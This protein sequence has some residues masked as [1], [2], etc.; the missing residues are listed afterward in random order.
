MPALQA[1]RFYWW[2]EF[3]GLQSKLSQGGLSALFFSAWSGAFRR[4][5][6]SAERGLRRTALLR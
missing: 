1:G 2:G 5:G 6:V 3:L 4:F